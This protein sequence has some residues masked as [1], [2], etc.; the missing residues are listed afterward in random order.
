[1]TAAIKAKTV[2]YTY[3]SM[4]R[5]KNPGKDVPITTE[6]EKTPYLIKAKT[7]WMLKVVRN[8]SNTC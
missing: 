6:F 5:G 2:C 7:N 3:T 4:I 8:T 1:M